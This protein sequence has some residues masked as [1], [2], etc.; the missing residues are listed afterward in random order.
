[1]STL[2]INF[3]HLSEYGKHIGIICPSTNATE[4]SNRNTA[5]S[6]LGAASLELNF[7]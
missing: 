1:M 2:F 6:W 7:G 4:A 3:T 5:M